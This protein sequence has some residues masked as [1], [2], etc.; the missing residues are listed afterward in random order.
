MQNRFILFYNRKMAA[1]VLM[2]FADTSGMG[3]AIA[4]VIM[5]IKEMALSAQG[6]SVE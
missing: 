4:H 1:A 5:A 3:N 6:L 2:L